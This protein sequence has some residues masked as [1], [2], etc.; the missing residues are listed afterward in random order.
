[1]IVQMKKVSL[2]IMGDKKEE[3]LKKLRKLGIVHIEIAEGCGER[4]VELKDNI[5][6]LESALYTLGKQKVAEPKSASL[7]EALDISRELE[8]ITEKKR[9]Y[10]SRKVFLETELERVSMLGEL[11]PCEFEALAEKGIA[12]SIYEMPRSEYKKLD[13]RVKTLTIAATKKSVMFLLVDLTNE[14]DADVLSYLSAYSFEL[15]KLSTTEMR[16]ELGEL[17]SEIK[18]IDET[19]LSYAD[20]TES[21]KDAINWY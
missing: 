13:G 10:H 19:V 17:K 5:S 8:E 18:K 12:L 9:A 11:Y 20:Y 14:S 15:P 7:K 1:M 4:L 6:L 2:V 3:A 21:I 16:R